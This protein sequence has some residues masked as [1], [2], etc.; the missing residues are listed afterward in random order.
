[1]TLIV[2]KPARENHPF[3]TRLASDLRCPFEELE[4]NVTITIAFRHGK[5]CDFS[6]THA[7]VEL[8]GAVDA[9]EADDLPIL[10]LE[11]T[12]LVTLLVELINKG[13][14]KHALVER[15]STCD[16]RSNELCEARV[17]SGIDFV[18]DA[19]VGS[20]ADDLGAIYR[21]G[22]GLVI[23]TTTEPA[24]LEEC[25]ARVA[26]SIPLA[27]ESAMRAFLLGRTPIPVP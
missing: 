1:M 23:P 7:I 13:S 22:I 8:P 6:Y 21:E 17:V 16:G 25:L 4:A 15:V 9:D 26:V 10:R 12:Q 3:A 18:L 20:R 14:R 19:I 5:L 24:T 11:D 27:G 2:T